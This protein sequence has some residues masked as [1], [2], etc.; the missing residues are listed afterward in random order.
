MGKRILDSSSLLGS[1]T[2]LVDGQGNGDTTSI[3]AALDM[4]AQYAT[5]EN[6]WSVRVAPGV[7][8]E[9]LRLRDYVDLHGLGPGRAI[10]LRRASGPLILSPAVC[11]LGDLWLETV[12]AAVLSLGSAFSGRIELERVTIDQYA[13]DVP[14]LQVAGGELLAARCW[15]ASGGAV[16]LSGGRLELRQT[17]LRNQAEDD[18]GQNMALYASGG[19]LRLESCVIENVSPAG[20]AAYL[21]ASTADLRA[22]SSLFRKASASYAIHAAQAVA[23]PL[24][25]CCGNGPLHPNLSGAQDYLYDSSY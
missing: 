7:Y 18:G 10:R 5:A 20:Y 23:F 3:Q 9:A 6:R 19:T 2:L 11:C 1:Q 21:D 8:S 14:A 16:A 15:L 13:L 17:T 22:W 4:A 25:A 24:A 12:D